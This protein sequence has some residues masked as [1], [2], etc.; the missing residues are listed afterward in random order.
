MDSGK[1]RQDTLTLVDSLK[2]KIDNGLFVVAGAENGK[3]LAV[4]AST[5]E[6]K[7]KFH[8][9]NILKNLLEEFG[10]RGGGKPDMAQGG[11]PSIDLEKL[12]ELVKNLV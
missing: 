1:G 9:G 12:K 5:G 10:G 2:S 8:A 4:V 11:A 7:K 6:A 3:A